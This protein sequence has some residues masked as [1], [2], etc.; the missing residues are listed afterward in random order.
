MR[1]K[2][3]ICQHGYSYETFYKIDEENLSHATVKK[4][5]TDITYFEMHIAIQA[6]SNGHILFS[7]VEQPGPIDPVYE[8]GKLVVTNINFL[9]RT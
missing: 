2:E 5:D 3:H 6:A 8:I 7:A 9:L 1:C 4:G